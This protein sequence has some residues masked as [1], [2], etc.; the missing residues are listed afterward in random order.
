[1]CAL[2]AFARGRLLI[3]PYGI[4]TEKMS[5]AQLRQFLLIVPYGIETL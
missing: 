2:Q 4:E 5:D 3:V 1:M